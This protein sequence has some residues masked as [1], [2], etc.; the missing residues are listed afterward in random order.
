MMV[1]VAIADFKK[2]Y[3][4]TRKGR[5]LRKAMPLDQTSLALLDMP[6]G[7]CPEDRCEDIE[8]TQ[9]TTPLKGSRCCWLVVM[10]AA[11]RPD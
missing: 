9:G 6:I 10:G 11:H 5:H 1:R 4:S 2:I 3:A 7:R 8:I